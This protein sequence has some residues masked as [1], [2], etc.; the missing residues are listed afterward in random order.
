[1]TESET[2][3][4]IAHDLA[5]AGVRAGGPLLVHSSLRSLGHAPAGAE[6]VVRGLLEALGPHGTLLMPALSYERVTS[7]Q[8]VF[9]IRRTPGNVGAIPE[10]FRTRPGT[11]RSMHPTHSVCAVGRLAE[12][13]LRDHRLDDT[14]VG[15]HS[16]FR[17]LPEYGGQILM[18]GCGLRPN[19]SLHGI[20][21]LVVPPYLYGEPLT[22]RL[23]DWAGEAREKVY[24][25]HGFAGWMQ[26]YDRVAQ[27]LDG[28]GLRRGRVLQAE[29]YLI[30]ASALWESALAALRR[31]PL[32][33]VDRIAL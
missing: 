21:E 12:P 17:L 2:F 9:D 20:E 13:M 25:R 28:R 8:P 29:V 23:V 1:M 11:L 31:D 7:S 19:T 16:P 24:R 32:F 5:A 10:H 6:T 22:Y 33:F 18:L 15:P 27:V 14:P 26:R 3:A 30:E 4:H